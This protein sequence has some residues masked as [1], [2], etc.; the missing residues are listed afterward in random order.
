MAPVQQCAIL[1]VSGY[2][3]CELRPEEIYGGILRSSGV[4]EADECSREAEDCPNVWCREFY[5]QLRYTHE[6]PGYKGLSYCMRRG[7]WRN[8][9]HEPNDQAK[10]LIDRH[11]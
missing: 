2:W 6:A 4:E 1:D 7:V 3:E 9:P 11:P 8:A 10:R 5:S